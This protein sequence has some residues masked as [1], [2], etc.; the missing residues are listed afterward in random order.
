MRDVHGVIFMYDITDVSSFQAIASWIEFA[1]ANAPDDIVKII[2]GNKCDREESREVD[3]RCAK[4][5]QLC[6]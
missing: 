3:K 5:S 6:N 1:Q 2:V 4:V